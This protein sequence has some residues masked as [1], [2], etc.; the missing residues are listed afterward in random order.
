[1]NRI[2][3]TTAAERSPRVEAIFTAAGL[4]PV[5]LPCVRIEAV[6]ARVIDEM[7]RKAER[8]DLVV[9]T[10]VTAL[11]LLWGEH[12]PAAPVA[13]V[14]SATAAAVTERGGRVSLVGS[15][16]GLALA[17]EIDAP[18]R[19]V[20]FPHAQGTDPETLRLLA[21]KVGN[22]DAAPVYRTVPIPP[23]GDS[24]DAVAFGSPSAVRGWVLARSL[25]GPV[26]GAIG[27][28][29]AGQVESLGGTVDVMPE[30]PRF[31]LLAQALSAR[32]EVHI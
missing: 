8:A 18:G 27:S 17:A 21:S 13:A 4:R 15:S 24:V 25:A 7:R 1:M 16:T 31:D 32:L 5:R 29:T 23:Q 3:I 12:A 19:W 22:L 11:N 9:L 10:S 20:V 30:V 28:R 14:G 2:G 6:P 26:V